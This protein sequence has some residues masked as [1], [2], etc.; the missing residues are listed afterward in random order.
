MSIINQINKVTDMAYEQ[1][2][3]YGKYADEFMVMGYLDYHQ[4]YKSVQEYFFELCENNHCRDWK[5]N[6][7]SLL[8]DWD[9]KGR[10]KQHGFYHDENSQKLAHEL[11]WFN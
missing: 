10:C 1:S 6:F 2:Q 7:D 5:E 8:K 4:F 3:K 9:K 11:Y